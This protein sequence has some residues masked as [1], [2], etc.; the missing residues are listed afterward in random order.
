MPLFFVLF[1]I[2]PIIE[3]SVLISVGARIGA[4][5]TIAL[6]LLSAVIGSYLLR[7]QGLE[8]LLRAKQRLDGGELP[9]QEMVEGIII[10][11]G[12]A[13]LITPG[14]VT[15]F[16]GLLCLIPAFRRAVYERFRRSALYSVSGYAV[17][18]S[19][20]SSTQFGGHQQHRFDDQSGKSHQHTPN[21]LDGEFRREE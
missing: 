6:V 7:Q 13:L 5:N 17:D 9:A 11:V 1:V 10:A 19:T 2:M 8:T 3:M 14:F 4:L 15:D 18:S 12:A 20:Q 21:T 16:M